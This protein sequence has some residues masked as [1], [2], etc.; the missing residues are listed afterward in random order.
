M[1]T[2]LQDIRYTAR[3]FRRNPLFTIIVVMTLALAIGANTAIFSLLNAVLLRPLPYAKADRVVMIWEDNSNF[4]FPRNHTSPASSKDWKDRN[5]TFEQMAFVRNRVFNLTGVGDPE[6]VNAIATTAN[7]FSVLG[8]QPLAGRVFREDEEQTAGSQVVLLSHTFWQSRFGGDKRV[9]GQSIHLDDELYT[10]MGIMPPDFEF[11]DKDTRIWLPL[12]LTPAES[13]RRTSHFLRV[14]GL[15]KPGVS[16]KQADSDMQNIAGQLRKEYPEASAKAGIALV[17]LKEQIVGDVR[18]AM[19]VLLV[20]AGFVLLIACSNVANLM[21]ARMASRKREFALRTALGANSRRLMRQLFTESFVIALLSGGIGLLLAPLAFSVLK[22]F[23][24]VG[25]TSQSSLGLDVR[26]LLFTLVISLLT[27][28]LF[29]TIPALQSGHMNLN[30]HLKQSG[31]GRGVIGGASRKL[32]KTLVVAEVGL[33]LILV[34]GAG[35]MIQTYIGLRNVKLGFNPEKV[36]TLR[37]SLSDTKYPNPDQRLAFLQQTL[38]RVQALPGVHAAGYTTVLPLTARGVSRGFIIEGQPP[39]AAG[40]MPL[41][42]IRVVSSDYLKTM[43]IPLRKGRYLERMDGP[44]AHVGVINEA[45]AKKFWAGQDP[46]GRQFTLGGAN[47]PPPITIV[48]IVGDEKA[49]GIDADFRPAMYLS[50]P[51]FVQPNLVPSELAIRT[52]G[53]PTQLAPLVRE[54]IWSID[55]DQ[56]ISNLK[57]MEEIVDAEVVQRRAY[58]WLLSI[59]AGLALLQAILGIYGVLSYTVAQQTNEIGILMALGANQRNILKRILRQGVGLA[60]IGIAIGLFA[61]VGLT[62]FASSLLY[63]IS[64]TDPTTFVATSLMILAVAAFACYIP[65]RR[66]TKVNPVTALRME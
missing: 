35:L 33:A 51:Q 61:A 19:W 18:P 56:P 14:V 21:L 27:A 54:Q 20:V 58:M 30:K 29:G 39:P 47:P 2:L 6:E 62:R 4:G 38:D 55:R 9:I 49:T 26:A 22:I 3:T 1:E 37:T 50:Y 34:I 7:L 8:V 46:I 43:D 42:L 15:L 57:T 11:P 53:D 66:A 41:A 31:T 16:F 36:L 12:V 25:L 28:I 65:A 59:F 5:Q 10:V 32:Q 52:T 44:S 63:G 48:G 13:T 45:M 23:V 17:P 60:V 40:D 64:A 24:P